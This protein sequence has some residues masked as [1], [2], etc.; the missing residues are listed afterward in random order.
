MWHTSRG[1]RTLSGDEAALISRAIAEMITAL[2]MRVHEDFEEFATDCISGI[3]IYDACTPSQ[4]IG[5]LHQ[6]ANY[7]LCDTETALP[8]NALTDATVAAVFAEIRDQVVIE[9]KLGHQ[10]P[11]PT[12][13][14]PE[15]ERLSRPTWRQMVLSAHLNCF[16]QRYEQEEGVEEAWFP[17][18]N[19]E[20][21]RVWE[22]LINELSELILWDRDF[23]LAETFLDLDPNI[24]KHRRRLLGIDDHYFSAVPQ[25]LE[26]DSVFQ[27]LEE[28]YHLVRTKPR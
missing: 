15:T 28:T 18:I 23:E 10:D 13:E 16:D 25:D 19:C 6:V 12:I 2:G 27:V 5:L 9:I 7:L 14:R 11:V 1:D 8:L 3:G 26:A 4:R 22:G 24:S 17:E 20:E 21:S